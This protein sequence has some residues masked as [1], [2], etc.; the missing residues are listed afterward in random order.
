VLPRPLPAPSIP[1]RARRVSVPSSSLP[2][3]DRRPSP[4]S[5][6][7][8]EYGL[9]GGPR[10]YQRRIRTFGP[11]LALAIPA[12]LGLVAY[13][14]L[15]L[16]DSAW[17]GA[18]GLLGGYFAGPALLAIGA[19]FADREIYPIA[20]LASGVMWLLVGLLAS[21]RATRN[22]MA[23]WGDFWRHYFWMLLGIWIGVAAALAIATLQIGSDVLDW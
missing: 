6:T 19:P 3:T 10:W 13:A 15:Q 8:T 18:V 14:S 1:Y 22:P 2:P 11:L 12:A 5:A 20:A 7:N 17:S 23:T 16:S 4:S 21:R 9:T